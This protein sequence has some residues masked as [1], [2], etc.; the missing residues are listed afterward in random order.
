[1]AAD[2]MKWVEISASWEFDYVPSPVFD[3]AIH[4]GGL[5]YKLITTLEDRLSSF[6][7]MLAEHNDPRIQRVVRRIIFNTYLSLCIARLRSVSEIRPL[8]EPSHGYVDEISLIVKVIWSVT[9]TCNQI[10]TRARWRLLNLVNPR[11]D[12]QPT[13]TNSYV[14]AHDS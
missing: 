10:R 14:A 13:L 8:T 7:R 3:Y 9:F 1:V 12:P 5:S 2:Y 11:S 4:P 6:R